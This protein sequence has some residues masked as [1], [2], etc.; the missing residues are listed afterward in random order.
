MPT[1]NKDMAPAASHSGISNLAH[2]QQ[3]SEYGTKDALAVG[4]LH[5]YKIHIM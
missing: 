2:I 1:M 5:W 3:T 4:I